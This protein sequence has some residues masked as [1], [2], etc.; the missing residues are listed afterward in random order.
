[1]TSPTNAGRLQ[2]MEE[3]CGPG[4]ADDEQL[5]LVY[6]QGEQE[7]ID[8]VT[9]C[10]ASQRPKR[11]HQTLEVGG[12]KMWQLMLQS[13]LPQVPPPYT[14][15][16]REA[17]W[18]DAGTLLDASLAASRSGRWPPL[19]VTD[20]ENLCQ[21]AAMGHIRSKLAEM[22]QIRDTEILTVVMAADFGHLCGVLVSGSPVDQCEPLTAEDAK[23]AERQQ[24]QF[25]ESK[26]IR[27]PYG[28]FVQ[29]LHLVSISG[30]AQESSQS[31][32][33]FSAR[34]VALFS[35]G[36]A[37]YCA[38]SPDGSRSVEAAGKW[39]VIN[40]QVVIYADGRPHG[41]HLQLT[42]LNAE[43]LSDVSYAE[44]IFVSL[45]ELE[46]DF[47]PPISL[48]ECVP[49][50]GQL[51]RLQLLEEGISTMART[52]EAA[53]LTSALDSTFNTAWEA[54]E[55][56][57]NVKGETQTAE[58]PKAET[59]QTGT[60]P[61]AYFLRTPI[62]A[63]LSLANAPPV[64]ENPE[65]KPAAPRLFGVERGITT[66]L[67][68]PAEIGWDQSAR[69]PKVAQGPDSFLQGLRGFG[70]NLPHDEG[71]PSTFHTCA[72]KPGSYLYELGQPKDYSYKRLE[73]RLHVDGK[74]DYKESIQ[75]GSLR[76]NSG[77]LWSV[78]SDILVLD[79]PKSGPSFILRESRGSKSLERK[80]TKIIVPMFVLK[81]CSY[82]PFDQ[83][84]NPFQK[85]QS[86]PESSRIFGVVDPE[87]PALRSLR[88]RPDHLP[89]H[90]FE[91]EL[92]RQ[93]LAVDEILTD[94]RFIDRDA[95]G[96]VSV[97]DMRRLESYGTP[98]AAPEI[99]ED[100][101]DALVKN[102]GNLSAAYEALS[103]TAGAGRVA[104]EEFQ[105]FFQA[106]D[107]AANGT[108]TQAGG[109]P[110]VLPGDRGQALR[111]WLSQNDQDSRTAVFGS[112]CPDGDAIELCDFLSLNLHG[113]VLALRR[114]E[115]FQAWIFEGFGRTGEVFRKVFK[116]MGAVEGKGLSRKALF[117]GAQALGYPCEMR[118][119]RSVF[120]LLDRNF[121]GEV[122]ARE[123]QKLL[124]FNSEDVLREVEA[125]KR[126]A[127]TM[128]G[129]IEAAF[130]K[131]LERERLLQKLPASP[132][133]TSYDAFHK[134]CVQAG[135]NKLAPKADVKMLFLFFNEVSG[136]QTAG[137]LS[138]SEW[139][140]L[141]GFNSKAISG[142]PARLRR[143]LQEAYGSVDMAFQKMHTSWLRRALVKGLKQTA[144]AGLVHNVLSP[145]PERSPSRARAKRSLLMGLRGQSPGSRPSLGN[146]SGSSLQGLPPRSDVPGNSVRST[147]L[148]PL[149]LASRPTS[150]LLMNASVR[151]KPIGLLPPRRIP[152]RQAHGFATD[153]KGVVEYTGRE[154]GFFVSNLAKGNPNNVELLFSEKPAHR[155]WAWKELVEAR[156]CFLTLRCA[157]QYLGFISQRLLRARE[158]LQA[159]EGGDLDKWFPQVPLLAKMGGVQQ[160]W[161]NLILLAI[162]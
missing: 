64:E 74:C 9:C 121:D 149:D 93:G 114:L 89:F 140:L 41:A 42:K 117:E 50:G 49:R 54:T 30:E 11:R 81:R 91:R 78:E 90:A 125:M 128:L 124:D 77:A 130:A 127:D 7:K 119:M 97:D 16:E 10:Q 162:H 40:G 1:M 151:H 155:S 43:V 112:L 22:A 160:P 82:T 2:S 31:P 58:S 158:V 144:L 122:S 105:N 26:P 24:R 72:V 59:P 51:L 120:S 12:W 18:V 145:S 35:D 57:E 83:Q 53:V 110:L 129:G 148:P 134:V 98:F 100:L 99:L 111:T 79:S 33:L 45:A 96:L 48:A 104:Q 75:G 20:N 142:S 85:H 44:P 161:D 139:S 15:A 156:Q 68:G 63:L 80:V 25:E 143:V 21:V 152:G 4:P 61:G 3:K 113:A 6:C 17:F 29:R 52:S 133:T 138:F 159:A 123:F 67:P 132:K 62:H 87:S 136:R 36:R 137:M 147:P 94:F 27:V 95:D 115:H 5:V 88:C 116:A 73:M 60:D 109:R 28:V 65:P 19:L 157:K 13:G 37:A 8:V 92:R 135:F 118:V 141:K 14:T 146:R 108:G 38:I 55:K 71:T 102:F 101:R 69:G 86:L 32:C 103:A 84:N 106:L 131:F 23:E 153:K 150:S 66:S 34:C 46:S 47:D 76:A 56:S 39:Q 126:F 154:L 70:R 107:Q